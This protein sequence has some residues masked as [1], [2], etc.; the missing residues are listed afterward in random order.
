[1]ESP[2]ARQ[3]WAVNRVYLLEIKRLADGWGAGLVL[4]ILPPDVQVQPTHFAFY[5]TLGI[6]AEPR[7]LETARP[8]AAMLE[9]CTEHALRCF[10]LLPAL[11]ASRERELY[12]DQDTHWNA[13]GNR[14]AFEALRGR[15]SPAISS[16]S[17]CG[18]PLECL[19]PLRGGAAG[20][21]VA[22]VETRTIPVP[23]QT[24]TTRP[25][26]A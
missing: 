9:F 13:E 19:R 10:D 7:F 18:L 8:Q 26:G 1:M 2:A 20:D 6:R 17:A 3:A 23:S 22:T 25:A 15:L 14:V 12:L 16:L 11:R 5:Q 4:N 21:A 24:W